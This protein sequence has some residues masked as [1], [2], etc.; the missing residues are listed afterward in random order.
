[1][2]ITGVHPYADKFP[3]LPEPE[4]AE[5]AESI[6][7]NGLRNPIVL[8]PDGLILDGRNRAA[9]CE[10][11][12]VAPTT[13]V[14]EGDDL[15]EYVIDA[16]SSRR[17][18]TTGARAMATALVLVEDGRRINGKWDGAKGRKIIRPESGTNPKSWNNMLSQA[19]VVTDYRPDLADQ[20]ISAGL[21]IDAAYKLACEARDAERRK[22]EEAERLAAEEADAKAF[23]EERS[24]ELA[25][26]VDGHDLQS[27]VEAKDLWQRR[28]R[29]EAARLKREREERDRAERERVNALTHTYT[30]IAQAVQC[31]ASFGAYDDPLTIMRDFETRFVNPPQLMKEFSRERLGAASRFAL[32]LIDYMEGRN[33]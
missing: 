18:M 30:D 9:A 25:A 31:L 3:M 17:H 29:E 5:L 23:V 27:F 32:A 22:L 1:M 13:T 24:P 16:N 20:V 19:G 11:V 6:R 28:N 12:G 33:R 7:A 2:T 4:L 14:Y 10:R 8:T 26:R 21:A 15:A